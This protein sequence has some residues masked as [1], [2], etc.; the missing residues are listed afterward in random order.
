MR[1]PSLSSV[2]RWG[3]GKLYGAKPSDVDAFYFAER[4]PEFEIGAR[5][6]GL[7]DIVRYDD[8]TRL[9]IGNYCSFG[10][11]VRIILGGEHR[12]DWVTTYPFNV[13]DARF[14]HIKG[15]PHS[16]GD[17]RIGNDVWVGRDAMILSGVTIGDGAVVAA[18]SVVVRDVPAFA[19][20][21]GNPARV[22]KMRFTE[23]Q[24]AALEAIRWWDWDDAR[25]DNAVPFLQNPEIDAFIDR[26]TRGLL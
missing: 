22:L 26:A 6:Y 8:T 24:V 16:K 9:T 20:A 11:G 14:G 4:F 7:R 19:I 1:V 2:L 5:S 23:H 21:G 15:H 25:V 12:H 17:V 3:R 18:G 13:L 10:A